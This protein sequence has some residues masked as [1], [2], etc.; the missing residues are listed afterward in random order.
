M[1]GHIPRLDDTEAIDVVGVPVGKEDSLER[2][3]I[4]SIQRRK[5]I[6]WS[7]NECRKLWDI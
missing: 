2:V 3:D 7:V 1:T 4:L 6:L 5:N